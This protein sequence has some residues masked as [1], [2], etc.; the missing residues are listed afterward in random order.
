VHATPRGDGIPEVWVLGSSTESALLAGELGLPYCHAHFINAETTARAVEAYRGCFA[1]SPWFD[2]PHVSLGVSALCA[3]TEE[4][5]IRLS[6]SRYCWRFRHGGIPTVETA[7]AFQY[8]APEM[9]YI[10]YSRPR[11]AIGSP[12]QVTAKLRALADEHGAEEIVLLT[13]TYDFADRVRSY[14][15]IARAFGLEA[16]TAPDPA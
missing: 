6:W 16:D 1:P 12:E 8:S 3:P 4:E 10:E 2:A 9:E 11:A 13:I 15:L 5:A 7:L 14:E